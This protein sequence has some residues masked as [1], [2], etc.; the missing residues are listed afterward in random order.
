MYLEM[1]RSD[2]AAAAPDFQKAIPQCAF[3]VRIH[4]ASSCRQFS[5]FLSLSLFSLIVRE[6]TNAMTRATL[7]FHSSHRLGA[8]SMAIVLFGIGSSVA[9]P[10]L[11]A[12]TARAP[13]PDAQPYRDPQPLQDLLKLNDAQLQSRLNS[14]WP[15]IRQTLE[16]FAPSAA[17]SRPSKIF[18]GTQEACLRI[19][20]LPACRAYMSNLVEINKGK[21]RQGGLL[22]NPL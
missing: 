14:D 3:S 4:G 15:A 21:Q 19:R 16:G 17:A 5:S 6:R 2:V 12:Q 18:S 7:S 11:H 1:Y 13:A 9:T 8:W 20:S 10:N 22:A